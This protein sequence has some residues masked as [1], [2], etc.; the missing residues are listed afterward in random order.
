ML[1][2]ED[3]GDTS[4]SAVCIAALV[5]TVIGAHGIVCTIIVARIVRCGN[6]DVGR[7]HTGPHYKSRV[8]VDYIV[9]FTLQMRGG[10]GGVVYK[11][12][13]IQVTDLKQKL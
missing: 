11:Q 10:G 5:C 7:A 8:T 12:L 3:W 9:L 1:L 2:R 4:L 13:Y 6:G